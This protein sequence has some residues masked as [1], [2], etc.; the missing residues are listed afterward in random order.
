MAEFPYTITPAN[1]KEFLKHIQSA[2]VPEKVNQTYLEQV[3]FKSKNDR[4]IVGILKFIGFLDPNGVPTGVWT[5][6][7]NKS[8]AGVILASAIRS[9]YSD[10]FNTYPDANRKDNEALRDYF[11]AHTKVGD[12]ALVAIVGTFK[13]LCEQAD[14]EGAEPERTELPTT[15]D[16]KGGPAASRTTQPGAPS[17]PAIN[18]N[19]QLQL[20]ATEDGT[21]YEKLFA[22]LKKHLLSE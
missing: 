15:L 14:F 22:A 5:N 11:S 19:I 17:V 7:R 3:G 6:Y 16:R 18:I 21:I 2:G 4:N 10:L 1:L 20:P 8:A 12:R 9:G 13:T